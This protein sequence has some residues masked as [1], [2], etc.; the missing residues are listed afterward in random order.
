MTKSLGIL[1][2]T[3]CNCW[4][5]TCETPIVQL[6]LENQCTHSS[7]PLLDAYYDCY[8]PMPSTCILHTIG[9]NFLSHEFSLI[10]YDIKT[11][12][13]YNF[14]NKHNMLG[15]VVYFPSNSH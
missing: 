8:S 10:D 15:Q 14:F 2:C 5:G 3:H 9:G 6:W 13:Y 11:I 1:D 7:I 4:N 12:M